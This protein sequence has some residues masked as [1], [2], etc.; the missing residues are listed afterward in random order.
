MNKS[1][2][3]A[4]QDAIDYVQAC[5]ENSLAPVKGRLGLLGHKPRR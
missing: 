5:L 4:V 1:L 3:E 2:S